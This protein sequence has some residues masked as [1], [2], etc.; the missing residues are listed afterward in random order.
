MS[1]EGKDVVIRISD[2]KQS[3][4][5]SIRGLKPGG[6]LTWEEKK[7]CETSSNRW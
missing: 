1:N 3:N 4:R 6:C 7:L 5:E 2:N